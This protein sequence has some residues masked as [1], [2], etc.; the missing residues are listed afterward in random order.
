MESAEALLQTDSYDGMIVLYNYVDPV[1]KCKKV[2]IS[3]QGTTPT[4]NADLIFDPIGTVSSGQGIHEISLNCSSDGKWKY[5]GT[6]IDSVS[7]IIST[8]STA[9][10]PT[11]VVVPTISTTLNPSIRKLSFLGICNSVTRGYL[12]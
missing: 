1:T 6:V 10:P 5:M 11:T 9:T 8:D 7:C 2:D 12:I 4:E 3:C